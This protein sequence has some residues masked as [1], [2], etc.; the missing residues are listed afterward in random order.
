MHSVE[1]DSSVPTKSRSHTGE[2]NQ[3]QGCEEQETEVTTQKMTP[4]EQKRTEDRR[5]EGRVTK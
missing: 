1:L 2:P 4:Q 5:I 3:A